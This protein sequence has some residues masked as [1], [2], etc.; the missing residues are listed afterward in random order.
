MSGTELNAKMGK[1]QK[2]EKYNTLKN[3][4][5]HWRERDTVKYIDKENE[6]NVIG[7]IPSFSHF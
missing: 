6:N 1:T 3:F 2:W 7:A 4:I 5:V